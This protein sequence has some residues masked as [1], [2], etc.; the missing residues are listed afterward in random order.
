MEQ[1]G[2]ARSEAPQARNHGCPS[3]RPGMNTVDRIAVAAAFVVAIFVLVLFDFTETSAMP[4]TAAA[5]AVAN[6]V[7]AAQPASTPG[8]GLTTVPTSQEEN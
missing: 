4:R 1:V 7:P 8:R 2:K 6:S 3:A 5:A